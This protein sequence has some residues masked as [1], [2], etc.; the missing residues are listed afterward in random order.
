VSRRLAVVFAHPDDDTFGVTGTVALH[1]DDPGFALTAILLTSGDAGEIADP[2][3]ATPETLGE[4]RER[5]DRASWAALGVV[6]ERHEFLRY[7]DGHVA[8]QPAEELVARVAAILGE[9]RPDVVVTFGPDGI[10]GHADHVRAGEVTTEAFHRLRSEDGGGFR[11]LF[12]SALPES[13][14]RWF[15]DRLV[16][17]GWDP[18]DPSAPFQPRGV[19]DDAIAVDVDCSPVW[20][21]RLAAL[22][23]H[24]TQGGAG[25]FPDDLLQDLLSHEWFTQAWPPRTPEAGGVVGSVFEGIEPT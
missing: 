12:Y 21:R 23:E 3:L 11:G 1:A 17:R 9:Q 18:I 19:P 16:E 15:S 8:E 7:A 25:A 22:R 13:R 20:E 14:L 6:P 2:S 24:R 5:E 10:T 4:V